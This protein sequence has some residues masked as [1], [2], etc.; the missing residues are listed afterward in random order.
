MSAN[1]PSPLNAEYVLEYTYR[2]SVGP[3]LGQFLTGLRD[4]KIQGARTAN[5]KVLVPPPE[6]DPETGA[7]LTDLVDVSDCGV[8]TTWSWVVAPRKNHPLQ[9]PF[10]WALIRLDGADAAMLH[11]VDAGR[12]ESMSTGM[13]VRARWKNERVGGIG[14]LECFAPEGAR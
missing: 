3:I 12:M 11:V 14:D 7:S 10:A 6:A 1:E 4:R 9:R 5:G 2:R 13:R 8:V